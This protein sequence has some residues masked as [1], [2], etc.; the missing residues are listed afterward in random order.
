MLNIAVAPSCTSGSALLNPEN[1]LTTQYGAIL[2]LSR[3]GPET[4]RT[5]LLPHIPKYI[6]LLGILRI[7]RW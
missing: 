6:K 1:P 2:G 4:T 3:F 5:L 7:V